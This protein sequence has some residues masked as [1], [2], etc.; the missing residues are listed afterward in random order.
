[1]S[2]NMLGVK[3]S[4]PQKKVFAQ[5]HP[6][7]IFSYYVGA[8][9]LLMLLFH[10]TF[11]VGALVCIIMIHF[12]Q[13]RCRNLQ[14]WFFFLLI[15][16]LFI[17]LL[18]PIFNH[19]GRTVL[20]EVFQQRI[21]LEATM[22]GV[23]TAL[24]LMGVMALFV[25]YN[26]MMTPNKIFYLFSK[27]LPQFAVLLML[28]LRFIPLM[29]RRLEEIAA[30][31]ISKG[32]AVAQGAWKNRAKS[33]LL[34][35]Q[36]LLTYSLEEAIQTADSMKARGYGK[37]QRSAYD[38]FHVKKSDVVALLFF[39]IVFLFTAVERYFGHGLLTIYPMMESLELSKMDI[40]TMVGFFVFLGFPIYVELGGIHRWRRFN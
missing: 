26:E 33:G 23:T 36:V 10:P 28:T 39:V 8:L 21:T 22:F 7:V 3:K 24:T 11:L 16:S 38:Y 2:G 37:G 5:F 17:A 30:V 9:A 13:D 35:V 40:T 18:N 12:V 14:R 20:F 27:F 6:L 25:S 31:Q 32:I 4:N 29:R 1:M 34:Y 15:S 19:R